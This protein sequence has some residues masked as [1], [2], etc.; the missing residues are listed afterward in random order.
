MTKT[1]YV[2]LLARAHRSIIVADS[3]V[4]ARIEIKLMG[5]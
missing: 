5:A 3:L 1:K 2:R 4:A